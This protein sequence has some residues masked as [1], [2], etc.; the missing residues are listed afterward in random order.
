MNDVQLRAL[1]DVYRRM[2]GIILVEITPTRNDADTMR[3]WYSHQ[4]NVISEKLRQII[5]ADAS[6][7]KLFDEK[8]VESRNL[9]QRRGP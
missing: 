6:V 7:A 9:S 2:R 8:G 5:E 3:D 4:I 1:R